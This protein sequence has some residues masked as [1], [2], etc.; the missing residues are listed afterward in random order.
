ML[1]RLVALSSPLFKDVSFKEELEW[2]LVINCH[3][4]NT[5]PRDFRMGAFTLVPHIDVDVRKNHKL[6]YIK[7]VVIGPNP[8]PQLAMEA[9][10]RLLIQRGLPDAKI[11]GSAVPFRSL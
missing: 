5:P 10:E 9:V 4:F 6:D 3:S 2:R 8:H 11:T 1:A 7:E